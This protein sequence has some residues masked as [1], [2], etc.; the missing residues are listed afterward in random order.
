MIKSKN[1]KYCLFV[2]GGFPKGP[3]SQIANGSKSRVLKKPDHYG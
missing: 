2:N 3:L 1:A